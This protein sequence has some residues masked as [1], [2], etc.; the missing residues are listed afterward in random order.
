MYCW[1]ERKR[2]VDGAANSFYAH[3]GTTAGLPKF[4]HGQQTQPATRQVKT[5]QC[6]SKKTNKQNY[7]LPFLLGN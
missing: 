6:L 7:F 2:I 1:N 3:A 5:P 4:D